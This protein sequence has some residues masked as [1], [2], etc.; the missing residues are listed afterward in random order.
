MTRADESQVSIK[1]GAFDRGPNAHLADYIKYYKS[2][3]EP[4]FAVLVTG[5]WGTGKTYLMKQLLP[6]DRDDKQSYYV[7][8]FGLKSTADV[9]AALFTEA[10]PTLSLVQKGVKEVGE[11]GRGLSGFS[12]GIG[13]A[14]PGVANLIST[15]MRKEIDTS[16][17]IIFDDLER[18]SMGTPQEVLGVINY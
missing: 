3:K 18:S 6:W 10:H 13:G 12:F 14:L 1:A 16:R 8:L 15:L 11:A 4:G 7:S 2:L 9:D 17:P 5:E